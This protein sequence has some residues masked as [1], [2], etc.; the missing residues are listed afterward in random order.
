MIRSVVSAPNKSS[1]HCLQA[2]WNPLTFLLNPASIIPPS[3]I[4]RLEIEKEEAQLLRE[5]E[6]AELARQ[7]LTAR[8][9]LETSG[10]QSVEKTPDGKS[11]EAKQEEW[12][13]TRLPPRRKIP[14]GPRNPN[15]WRSMKFMLHVNV[16][17]HL[18][19]W[20]P[21]SALNG[22]NILKGIA[23]AHCQILIIIIHQ[24]I[25]SSC[26]SYASKMNLNYTFG[27]AR[28]IRTKTS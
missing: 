19:A 6:A 16:P 3:P 2:A 26:S 24:H 22:S 25:M 11:S 1:A 9:F 15:P 20:R 5:I 28:K 18:V 21:T 27:R 17:L 7:Q 23:V 8:S 12:K 4:Q 10:N 14:H 13:K